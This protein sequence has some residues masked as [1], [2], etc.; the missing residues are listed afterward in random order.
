MSNVKQQ[1]ESESID[2]QESEDIKNSLLFQAISHV[3][4]KY[5][6]TDD[7]KS[8]FSGRIA[9]RQ[10]TK[11]DKKHFLNFLCHYRF[12]CE[13][14]NPFFYQVLCHYKFLGMV[15]TKYYKN[16]YNHTIYK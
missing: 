12:L 5:M 11:E 14:T 9:T 10:F 15:E 13:I 2:A 1:M 4:P 6:Y 16:F 7:Y 3:L 8:C